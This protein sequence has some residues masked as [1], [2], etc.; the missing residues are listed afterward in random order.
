MNRKQE[1]INFYKK[2]ISI[3]K[4]HNKLYFNNDNTII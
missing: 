3:L 2:K 4:K 1:I